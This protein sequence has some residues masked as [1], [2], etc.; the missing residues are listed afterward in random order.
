MESHPIF[1]DPGG[2]RRVFFPRLAAFLVVLLAVVLVAFVASLFAAPVVQR[3]D[4]VRRRPPT[5]LKPIEKPRLPGADYRADRKALFGEIAKSRHADRPLSPSKGTVVAAFYAPWEESGVNSLRAYGNRLTHIIPAWLHLKA[6]GAELDFSDF[7]LAQNPRNGEMISTARSQGV[8]IMPLLSN[9]EDG[10]FDPKR[11]ATLLASP[12]RQQALANTL[13]DWLVQNDFQGLNIDLEDLSDDSEGKLPV[14]LKVLHDTFQP[15]GLELTCDIESSIES[16]TVKGAAAACDWLILM[17]YDEHSE[18]SEAGP[19]ASIGWSEKLVDRVAQMVPSDKLVL[20]IGSYAYDWSKGNA[21][22]LT[23]QEALENASGYRPEEKPQDVID[24]DQESLNPTFDYTDD[25]DKPHTVW[26]LDAATAYNQWLSGWSRGL[27]GAGLWVLGSE[28]PGVWSFLNKSSL[29]QEPSTSKLSQIN[30][31][32]DVDNQGRGEILKVTQRPKVGL[33]TIGKDEETDLVTDESYQ[34][35][36]SPYVIQ[37]SGYKPKDLVLTFDDGPDAKYTPEVLDELKRLGVKATF[38]VVGRNAEANPGLVRRMVDE[39]HEVGSHTFTHPDLGAVSL[40]RAELEI[41]ATQRAIQSIT[42]RSTTLFRP[43]YNADSE[44]QAPNEVEPI[45]IA[46]RLG[47]VS[48]GEK[49]DPLDWNLEVKNPDGSIRAKT[50]DDIAKA[51]IDGVHASQA[52][53][54]E[55]NIVLLHDAGGP[56]PATVAALAKFVPQLQREGYR[57]VSVADLMGKTR[58]QVMPPI[59]P[60]DR[61]AIWFDGL[62]FNA[63]FT[64]EATLAFCFLSAIGLGLARFAF[65][66]PLALR[67]RKRLSATAFDPAYQPTVSALIA[68]YNEEKVIRRTIESVLASDYPIAEVIVIDDGSKDG[69]A[70]VV[71]EAFEDDPRVVLVTQPNGGKASALNHALSMTDA[72]LVFCI[73][74]DTQLA[75]EAVRLLVR[76]FAR[77]EVAAVAGNVRVGNATNVLTQWQSLEYTTSQNLDR[78]AYAA[79][80]S[81]TVVPGAI[82][83]WRREAVLQVGA[84]QSDTLAEDMDLT[85]RLRR[86]GHVLENEPL[87]FAFT[88]AP[89]TFRAFFRQRF[90]WA[91]GTLQCLVKHR[92]ALGRHGWFGTLALPTLWL[93]QIVFQA[94]A[95]LIDLQVLFS[96]YGWAMALRGANGPNGP[97]ESG[98]LALAGAQAALWQV[99]FLYALFFA[100]ELVGGVV[101][102]RLEGERPK[103]LGWLFF[104]RFAYRQIMYGVIYKSLARALAGGREG[105]GKLERKGT[106][107]APGSR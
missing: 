92:G 107:V 94:L 73:D 20:G 74:A 16:G 19:I 88:E 56:R 31:P 79:L 5:L 57:F 49:I 40:V 43:P 95:P 70:Q 32:Y 53:G 61:F 30:F 29:V 45:N 104:Q 37:H 77:P 103:G 1:F 23:Y 2:K 66:T 76:H 46:D 60:G 71:S 8:R 72:E 42:G 48:V 54:E 14:F 36:P 18:G 26:M 80:N 101:A 33:R 82:G 97:S 106:V 62:V 24:F 4:V 35:Y 55:G 6:D 93:F 58:A 7:D 3:D 50:A 75:P 15:E 21:E 83:L 87:A 28:D 10:N 64:G 17:A 78:R 25:D 9:G 99:L 27:R 105:W 63:A 59:A 39:G 81:I 65:I 44:P 100:V 86:A 90:R 98:Q 85:W 38:F 51:V 13:R 91:Y 11:A 67:H 41:K 52:A 102:Y 22:S 34:T 89:D 47:Y 68:A 69:T 96:I 12:D 84:Y